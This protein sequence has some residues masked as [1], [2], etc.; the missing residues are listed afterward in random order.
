MKCIGIIFCLWIM[1]DIHASA[2][3]STAFFKK[4]TIKISGMIFGDFEYRPHS[5]SLLRGNTQYAGVSFPDPKNF[6]SF[7][8]RRV[9]LGADF[10]FSK[11]LSGKLLLSNEGN[12]DNQKSPVFSL[13]EA[14]ISWDGIY[15]N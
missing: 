9:Y 5:D 3:D 14:N 13:K 15:K 11:H 6:S 2:Q 7:D 4:P 12:L 10:G 1:V 8:I